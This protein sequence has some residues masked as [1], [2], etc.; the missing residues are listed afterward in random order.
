MEHNNR[1]YF[2]SLE[3]LN[4]PASIQP[5]EFESGTPGKNVV[6]EGDFDLKSSRRDFLKYMGFGISAATL[7]ACTKTPVKK[8]IPYV[9]KPHEVDPG[10]PNYYASYYQDGG[11]GVL[12]KTREGRPIK[13]EGNDLDPL[14]LGA[15][16]AAGQASVL[17]L[18]DE[19]RL[20]GPMKDG[21]E[22]TWEDLDKDVYSGLRNITRAGGGVAILSGSID[23]PSTQRAIAK[24]KETHPGTR[25]VQY[26]AVSYSGIRDAYRDS[27]GKGIIPSH[28]F[29][30]AE[31]IVSFNADFLGTWLSPVIFTKQ[32]S[33]VRDVTMSDDMAYHV[34][35][36][37]HL[38][39][40]G[41]KADLRIPTKPSEQGA[42]MV[43]IYNELASK[44][45]QATYGNPGSFN[46]YCSPEKIKHVA[47]ELWNSRNGKAI[48][49][50]GSN[51]SK[52]QAICI[53]INK[54]LG[55]YGSTV[56]IKKTVNMF[57]GNERDTANLIKDMKSGSIKALIIYGANPSY[58]YPDAAAF[59]EALGKVELTVSLSDRLDETAM[60]VR[61]VAPDHHWLESWNDHNPV[62]G[63]Y[64]LSQPT[65]SNIYNTRQAQ[66]SI[67]SWGKSTSSYYD[68]I[69]ETWMMYGGHGSG[70]GFEKFWKESLHDGLSVEGGNPLKKHVDSHHDHGADTHAAHEGANNGHGIDQDTITHVESDTTVQRVGILAAAGNT[71]RGDRSIRESVRDVVHGQE[72]VNTTVTETPVSSASEA[73]TEVPM[74]AVTE[75]EASSAQINGGSVDLT[76]LSSALISAKNNAKGQVE[77]TL[78]Q[79]T[80]IMDGKFSNNPWLLEL[81]DSVSKISWDNYACVSPV[82]ASENGYEDGDL[83][84]VSANGKSIAEI[85]VLLMP[86]QLS[87][88]ISIAL[89]YG[90]AMD[91][92]AGR[93]ANGIGKNVYPLILTGDNNIYQSVSGSFEKTGSGYP[94]AKTQTHHHIQIPAGLQK[95]D[96]P[97]TVQRKGDIVKEATLGA[98]VTH[99]HDNHHDT[100]DHGHG[101]GEHVNKVYAG[102]GDQP[103]KFKHLNIY[104]D[105]RETNNFYKAIHWGMSVNLNTCTGCNACV[106]A[107]Q[108]ENNIPVVGKDEVMR[109]R[110][111]HWIRIDRYFQT[112]EGTEEDRPLL[113]DDNPKVMFQPLMCQHCDNAPCENVCPVNAINHSS[114]GINQQIYNRCMGTR[115]CANN[116]PYKVRRFN[117]F[118]YYDNEEFNY[119]F[120]MNSGLGRMVLNPD[121]TVR[122]R[123]VMEKCNFCTQRIQAAK[124][125]AKTE[126]RGLRDGDVVTACQQA[127]PANAIQFGNTNDP[128]AV[129]SKVKQGDLSYR[130]VELLNTDNSVYYTTQVRNYKLESEI[131]VIMRE[132]E[133]EEAHS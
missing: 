6:E 96:R 88:T 91:D 128:E 9:E 17:S 70:A 42:A 14:S 129:V 81:P 67:L 25:H 26:D 77:I 13:I 22:T 52:Q 122:A 24:F 41:S 46:S 104:P 95:Q 97:S 5:K 116:C 110:E 73:S 78:Y 87:G 72:N 101:H 35:F 44:A 10:V 86:G 11:Y 119:N 63:Q 21:V 40:S 127:C 120:T 43:A 34:Q 27:M 94:L 38:S 130:I 61:Y 113:Y 23:S 28:D 30:K 45:G 133:T 4:S 98:L 132:Q 29:S 3:E 117:W 65:I 36:E 12:V 84:T 57:Q 99:R 16:T 123:G 121:V 74:D 124:L 19:G 32:Y 31:T 37:S 106:I 71:L 93:V 68:F 83:I 115:Y 112:V 20:H 126:N 111:L 92:T 100:D 2:K 33:Q 66:E 76:A 79:K 114:E 1:R 18:Y 75:G 49:V 54:L 82:W 47:D 69:R 107:C 48:V 39:L 58:N 125:R 80:G 131:P 89:G 109:R 53:E 51:D 50:C 15:T 90:R 118:A 62:T 8:A 64:N 60:N 105:W 55:S 56:D 102:E 108:S 7:A 59:N 103:N 85:P